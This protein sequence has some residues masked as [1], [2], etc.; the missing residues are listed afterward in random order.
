MLNHTA[1]ES[2]VVQ[3]KPS[4]DKFP[5]AGHCRWPF[6]DPKHEDFHFCGSKS[7]SGK[8]FCR[9]HYDIAFQPADPSKLILRK[10]IPKTP[11]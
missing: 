8:S 7:I 4:W 11:T 5:P 1:E 2:V 9:E 3:N 6:G 10:I